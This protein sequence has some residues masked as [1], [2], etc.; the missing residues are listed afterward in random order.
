MQYNKEHGRKSA[1]LSRLPVDST[2]IGI[3][4]GYSGRQSEAVLQGPHLCMLQ[5]VHVEQ[6]GRGE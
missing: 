5:L 6:C 1:G 3:V 2:G 4:V